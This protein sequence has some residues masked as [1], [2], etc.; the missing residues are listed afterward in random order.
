VLAS[1][2]GAEGRAARADQKAWSDLSERVAARVRAYWDGDDHEEPIAALDGEERA[3]LFSRTRDLP[4]TVL[5]HVSAVIEDSAGRADRDTARLF[6][7]AV[8]RAAD[9]RL[10]PALRTVVERQDAELLAPAARS[11]GA[12]ADPRAHGL[13][14]DAYERASRTNERL[15]L[16]AAL[17]TVGDARGLDYVR[18]VWRAGD[19]TM[20]VP[21]LEALA[22]LGST[23]DVQRICELVEASATGDDQVLRAAV[24][25]LGRIADSR[26]LVPLA[27]LYERTERSAL[28]GEI[29][30]AQAAIHAR[31][32]LLGEEAAPAQTA[33]VTWDTTK[34]AALARK[35][36]PALLRLRAYANLILGYLWRSVGAH[37]RAIA[38]LEAAATLRTG[39]VEPVLAVALLRGRSGE[40][41]Q[42]LAAFRR[43]VQIDRAY[44]ES[45]G[46]AIT[47]MAQAFLRRAEAMEREGRIEIAR[48]LTEE[49]HGFDLRRASE[50]VRAALRERSARSTTHTG[51][52][53]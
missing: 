41:S 25:T 30:E 40:T 11:L 28:R 15:V 38:R 5:R 53:R 29:E 20:L 10:L 22:E 27:R 9:P 52:A 14:K 48:G 47:A 31:M 13:L 39:W 3:L 32:E 44:V 51:G 6:V 1:L 23:D 18:D 12:T 16:A 49:I 7:R 36:D 21:V 33:V 19:Q 42:A 46:F 37:T 50:R 43:A 34:V 26:A 4:D 45:H 35:S 8:E 24:T 17:G 2:Q